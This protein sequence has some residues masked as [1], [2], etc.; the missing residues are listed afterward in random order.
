MHLGAQG[1]LAAAGLKGRADLWRIEQYA[2][3]GEIGGRHDPHQIFRR[4]VRLVDQQADSRDGFF[5]VVRGN[6]GGQADRDARSA[7]DK[8]VRIARGQKIGFRQRIIKIKAERHGILLNIRKHLHRQR[9]HAGF[10]IAHR[11]R[12]VTIDGAE[13]A[14]AV[15]Q[16]AAHRKILRHAYRRVIYTAVAVGMVFSQA[17]ADDAG[18]LAVRLV[19]RHPQFMHGIENAPLNG[20]QPILHAGQGALQNDMLGVGH[21]ALVKHILKRRL[22][23]FR[24]IFLRLGFLRHREPPSSRPQRLWVCFAG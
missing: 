17:V 2:A 3:G 19:R 20:F 1:Q 6:V 23:Y 13:V 11:G 16:W 10:G 15:H 9:G 7:V 24:G 4:G 5:Q 8:E 22:D 14:V 18:T 21:H 12:A